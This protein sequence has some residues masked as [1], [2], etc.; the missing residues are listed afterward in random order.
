M[1]HISPTAAVLGLLVT[2]MGGGFIAWHMWCFDRFQ[3]LRYT[4]KDSFRWFI[5]WML[6]FALVFVSDRYRWMG[7]S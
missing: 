4:K 6:N 2:I 1:C 5:L 7:R 3:C